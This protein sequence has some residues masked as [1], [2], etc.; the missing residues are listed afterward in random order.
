MSTPIDFDLWPDVITEVTEHLPA[1]ERELHQLVANPHSPDLLASAFRRMHTMKGDFGYCHATP[2]M[3]YMHHLENVMQS[4]RDQ[5]FLCSPFIAEALIQSMDQVQ[6]MM[7][8]VSETGMCDDKPRDRLMRLIDQLGT[9]TSQGAADTAARNVL[10]AAHDSWVEDEVVAAVPATP[11]S[12]PVATAMGQQLAAALAARLPAWAGR[13]KLQTEV[14]LA[15]NTQY[16]NRC[17]PDSLALAVL[18]HDVGM[19]ALPDALLAKAPK[20]KSADWPQYAAHPQTASDWLLAMAPDCVDAARMVRQHH[21]WVNGFGIRTAD[22]GPVHPGAL[23]IGCADLLAD[24][25]LGQDEEGYRR[26]VLRTLFDVNGGLDTRF[27]VP[28][29]NAF[30]VVARGLVTDMKVA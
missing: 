1:L 21:Q 28:L 8:A 19:L 12:L 16:R 23:M 3:Q 7:Q 14:A 20:P 27:D 22:E 15:L 2:I 24:N 10:L 5:R 30:E 18:W 11:A 6:E 9:A 29:I 25:V 17:N 13:V 26:G 4:L